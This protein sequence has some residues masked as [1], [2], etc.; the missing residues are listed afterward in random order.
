M[1]CVSIINN[2]KGLLTPAS[3]ILDVNKNLSKD[4]KMIMKYNK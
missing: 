2:A 3:W 4:K 1:P